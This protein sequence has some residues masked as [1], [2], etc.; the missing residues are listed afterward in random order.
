MKDHVAIVL[1]KGTKTLFVQR[2]FQK[3][4]LPGLWAFPSGTMRKGETPE[5]TALREA[6]EELGIEITGREVLL[7]KELPR[8]DVRLH[9]VFCTSVQ[10]VLPTHQHEEFEQVKWLTFRE[11][12]AQLKD[13]EIG[14]GLRWLR[15]IYY[16][17]R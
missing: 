2:S 10:D 6:R 12:F 11:F 13:E 14:D 8:S 3:R 5:Q 9:F 15:Q 17:L 16:R 7:V 4:A 1:Q